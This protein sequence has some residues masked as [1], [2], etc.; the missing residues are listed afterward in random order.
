MRLFLFPLLLTC[1]VR[2]CT[3]EIEHPYGITVGFDLKFGYGTAVISY[4]NGTA[5]EVIRMES[6]KEY[7]ETFRKLSLLDNTH[8]A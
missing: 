2:Q 3:C 1:A 5:V 7:R 4:P 6:G 8:L